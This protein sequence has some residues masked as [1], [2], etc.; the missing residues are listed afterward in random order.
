MDGRI[1]STARSALLFAGLLLISSAANAGSAEDRMNAFKAGSGDQSISAPHQPQLDPPKNIAAPPQGSEVPVDKGAAATDAHRAE[2]PQAATEQHSTP[3]VNPTPAHGATGPASLTPE[4]ALKRLLEGNKRM[5]SGLLQGPDRSQARRLEVAGGQKPFAVV[6]TCS[7]SRVPPELL[8]DQGYGDIFVVRTAGNVVDD[9]AL[10]SIEYAIE[11]LGAKLVVVLGHSKCG[12]VK[13]VVDGG[14]LPGHLPAIAGMIQ[15]AVEKSRG[16]PGEL[17]ANAVRMNVKMVAQR[18]IQ[19]TPEMTEK[20]E[21]CEIRV[22]GGYYDLETG[23]V[24][25]TFQ[26]AI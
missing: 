25:I 21:D 12:A 18:I 4:E 16:K 23:K 26:S 24:Q 14:A 9:V 20:V 22:V 11:H 17:M 3:G 10:G 13:A 8:F 6:V 1:F 2:E 7:D 15:P 19:A 5:V